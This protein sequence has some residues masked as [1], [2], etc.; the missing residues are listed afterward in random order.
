MRIVKLRCGKDYKSKEEPVY[1]SVT[2][3]SHNL[4]LD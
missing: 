2:L 1:E 4:S 3:I